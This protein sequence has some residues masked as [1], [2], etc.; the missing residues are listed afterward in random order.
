MCSAT[1]ANDVW[2]IVSILGFALIFVALL[3]FGATR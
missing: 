3:V 2:V 1:T